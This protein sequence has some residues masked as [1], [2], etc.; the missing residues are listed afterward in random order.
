MG[1]EVWKAG[2]EAEVGDAD[3]HFGGW[4]LWSGGCVAVG[5]C[6]VAGVGV[7]RGM[8]EGRREGR[9][10]IRCLGGKERDATRA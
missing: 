6:G 7:E 3:G 8:D 4:K 2:G 10:K 1:G 9:R 5:S